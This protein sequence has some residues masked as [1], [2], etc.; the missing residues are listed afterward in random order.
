MITVLVHEDGVTRRAPSVDPAWLQPG[1][2]VTVWV[3]IAQPEPADRQ[4]L[5][6]LFRF[7]ELS[8]EDA[9]AEVHHPKIES[10]DSYLYLILHGIAA[11]K[12]HEGFVTQDVDF[13]LGPNYLVTVRHEDEDRPQREEPAV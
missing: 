10:Y 9:L 2:A 13:F 12:N 11:G 3:D 5:T 7:H 8:V 1:A 6:D 4:L